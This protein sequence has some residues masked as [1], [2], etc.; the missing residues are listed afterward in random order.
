MRAGVASRGVPEAE[1]A[2]LRR[3]V[4]GAVVLPS[5]LVVLLAALAFAAGL[6]VPEPVQYL[7]F[8]ASLLLFGLPHGAVDHLVPA[9]L[10]GHD[11]DARGVL[12]VVLLYLVL[13][14]P[15]LALWFV[16]P[17]VAF[18]LFVCVT[19]FHWGAGDLHALVFFGSGQL[20]RMGKGTRALLVLLRGGVPM[21][22]PLLFFP[23][24]YRSVASETA[25]L[26]G[27]DAV[28]LAWAFSPGFRFGA[29]ALLAAVAGLFFLSAVRDLRGNRRALAIPA[30][31]TILLVF[32]FAVVPPVLAVGLYFALWHAPRHIARL[33]L[34][35][36]A[37]SRALAAGRPLGA[38]ARFGRD[39]APLTAVAV[40]LLVG[41]YVAVPRGA[42]GADPLL[43]LYLVLVSAFTLPHATLVA[44][45]DVRQNV[46]K[47]GGEPVPR[48]VPA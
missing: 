48:R 4:R 7:P 2:D 9:R 38:L 20:G 21:L 1:P 3:A 30:L 15:C 11:P 40:L 32:F 13:A 35:D 36:G 17:G 16:A 14:G 27:G 43:A 34:L 28:G 39:A 46:W 12:G 31:E 26:F 42:V 19:V 25:A 29:G 24:A 22:V 41:L 45:M 6:R 47:A 33:V 37:A 10:S 8:A 5:G 18:V 23:D 44:H